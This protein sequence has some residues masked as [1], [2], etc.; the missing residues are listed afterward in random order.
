[1]IA[2][3]NVVVLRVATLLVSGMRKHGV[4]DIF[5]RDRYSSFSRGGAGLGLGLLVVMSRLS[6]ER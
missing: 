3:L 6:H 1:M 2:C 4:R 5:I